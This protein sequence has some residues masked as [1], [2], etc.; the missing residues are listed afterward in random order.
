MLAGSG[1]TEME[2]LQHPKSTVFILGAGFSK[3]AGIPVQ[4]E[5]A[6]LLVSEEFDSQIN[7]TI[8]KALKTF[9]KDVFGWR[10]GARFPA[11]EDIFTCIDLSAGSG[12]HLGISYTPKKL[13]ALRRIA[14]YRIFSV[15]DNKYHH[16]PAIQALLD[17]NLSTPNHATSFIVLNWD[18]VLEKHLTES[19]PPQTLNYACDALDWNSGERRQ[20]TQP[21][22]EVCKMHGSSNW[23]YCENCKSLF[24]DL[25]EKLSLRKKVGLI[26][27]DFRILDTRFVGRV[28]DQSLGIDPHDRECRNC[29]NMVSTH[30]ATFSYR[31]SFRT[32]A[33][34][35]IWNRAEQNLAE[36]DRWIFV[37]YSLPKADFE[38]KHLIKV[39]QL[40]MAHKRQNRKLKIEVI[41]MGETALAEYEAFF[42]RDSFSYCRGGLEGYVQNLSQGA[43]PRR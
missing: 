30:I 24:Y 3:L 18:I 19:Q 14:I 17:F 32:H 39:A 33:Y 42:G 34:A 37:G 35:S 2:K 28:F 6:E 38:L 5:F 8:T 16:S 12:L 13:R 4:A 43:V 40:R 10:N 27:A 26:K 1:E 9:L 20:V 25:H 41:S 31:K 7:K 15:L 36:A 29:D 23:V 22:L 21:Q 11:L